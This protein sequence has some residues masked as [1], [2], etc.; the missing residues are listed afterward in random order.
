MRERRS[1]RGKAPGGEWADDLA[2]DSKIARESQVYNSSQVATLVWNK[3]VKRSMGLSKG[4]QSLE[5]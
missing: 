2:S 4:G 3:N 1:L 5:R